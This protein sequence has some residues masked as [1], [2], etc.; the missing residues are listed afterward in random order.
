MDA[1]GWARR[2]ASGE[3]IDARVAIVVAHPDDET[4]WTGA[5]LA[6]ASDVRLIHVTDGAPRDME[7]AAR[8]G[9]TSREAYADARDSEIEEALTRL[10]AAPARERYA[11][12]DKEAVH[13]LPALARRLAKNLA[14]AALV[15]T[16]PYE[17]GHPDHDAC[18]WAVAAACDRLASAAPTR[19]E[20]ACYNE[21]ADERVFGRF[22]PE[23]ATAGEERSLQLA[24]RARLAHAIAAHGTQ[25][26]VIGGWTPDAEH[27]RVPPVHDFSRPPPGPALYDRFG[28]ELTSAR[29][30]DLARAAELA[31]C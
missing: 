15:V 14:G 26:G 23:P 22:A 2:L 31:L 30:C 17:G 20:F 13:H 10:G 12:P 16:H 21:Q 19:V 27:W 11:L 4:L 24:E 6:R 9:F 3:A 28:W 25:A 5:L 29:W 7:D 8:M 18:A 1:G